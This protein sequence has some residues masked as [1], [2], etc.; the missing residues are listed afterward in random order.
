MQLFIQN[1]IKL[2]FYNGAL[3]LFVIM[4]NTLSCKKE[5][6]PEYYVTDSVRAYVSFKAGSYWI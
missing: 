6:I 5:P 3:L 1:S 2:N 4:T